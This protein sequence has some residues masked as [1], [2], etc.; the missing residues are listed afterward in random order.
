MQYKEKCKK[1]TNIYLCYLDSYYKLIKQ[2]WQYLHTKLLLGS[3]GFDLE[4]LS[5]T[6]GTPEQRKWYNSIDNFLTKSFY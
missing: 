5:L 2:T 3:V 4:Y 1:I 6:G